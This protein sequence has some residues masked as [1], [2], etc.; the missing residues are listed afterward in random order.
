VWAGLVI[1]QAWVAAGKPLWRVKTLGSFEH[2]TAV[3][4][5]I[6]DVAGVKGFLENLHDFYKS[7]FTIEGISWLAFVE[8]WW[9][10]HGSWDV[11]TADLVP[12][13][14]ECGIEL[15][16]ENAHTQKISLGMKL[17]GKRD[18]VLGDFRILQGEKHRGSVVWGLD[19][20]AE[21]G[22]CGTSQP[23]Q[24]KKQK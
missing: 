21:R 9:E 11:A 14:L 19:H 7:A 17:K 24:E 23:L 3:M 15:K 16:G 10:R 20:L 22:T 8:M 13:A 2:W 18:T 5:G 12:I 1:V 4:G 6:L